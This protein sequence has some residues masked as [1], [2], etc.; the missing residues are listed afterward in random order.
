MST[1][2]IER[3]SKR[4]Y[5]TQFRRDFDI[6]RVTGSLPFSSPQSVKFSF[7]CLCHFYSP[8]TIDSHFS[9][10]TVTELN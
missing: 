1:E 2:L 9:L 7:L 3:L 8:L 5:T 4:F 10:L 6:G